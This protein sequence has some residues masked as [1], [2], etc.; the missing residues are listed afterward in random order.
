MSGSSSTIRILLTGAFSTCMSC[1]LPQKRQRQG[2]R[3]PLARSAVHVHVPA[4]SLHDMPDQREPEAAA[5]RLVDQAVLG[6]IELL[7]DLLL[8]AF[9]DADPEIGDD[10]LDPVSGAPHVDP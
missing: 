10:D 6:P 7:E 1:L 2:E 4:V 8:F 3:A 5:L 9:R